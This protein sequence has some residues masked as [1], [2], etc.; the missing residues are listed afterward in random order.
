MTC[1]GA[2]WPAWLAEFLVVVGPD[3]F[4]GVERARLQR[5]VNGVLGHRHRLGAQNLEHFAGE[6]AD[7]HLQAGKIAGTVN[8]L[9]KPARHLTA[10]VAGGKGENLSLGEKLVDE[11]AA[12]ALLQPRGVLARVHAERRRGGEDEARVLAPV[13]GERGVRAFGPAVG[14]GVQRFERRRD[15]AGRRDLKSEMTV[16]EIGERLGQRFAAAVDEVERRHETRR[17]PPLHVGRGIGE[18][19]PRQPYAGRGDS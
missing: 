11:V 15:F 8:L 19:R 5:V 6:T 1:R 3:P 16:G 9:A 7:A 2:P 12:A 17:Y 4:E 13:I 14:D 10:G 18:R